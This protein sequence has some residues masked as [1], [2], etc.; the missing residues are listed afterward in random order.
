MNKN[1]TESEAANKTIFQITEDN[2]NNTNTL[3]TNSLNYFMT[4]YLQQ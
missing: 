4:H 3:T 1:W 2:E